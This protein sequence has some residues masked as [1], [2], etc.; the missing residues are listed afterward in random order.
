MLASGRGRRELR[1]PVPT[2]QPVPPKFRGTREQQA[3]AQLEWDLNLAAQRR[4]G[5]LPPAYWDELVPHLNRLGAR[6]L[7]D[8]AKAGQPFPDAHELAA[9]FVSYARQG[10]R[11]SWFKPKGE[12]A[13]FVGIDLELLERAAA[14]SAAYVLENHDPEFLKQAQA[15]GREGGTMHGPRGRTVEL[16]ELD[17]YEGQGI[18]KVPELAKVMRRS[19]RT[20]QRLRADRRKLEAAA[21]ERPTTGRGIEQVEAALWGDQ[22]A[23]SAAPAAD[24][25]PISPGEGQEAPEAVPPAATPLP[26][27]AAGAV[28]EGGD[29]GPDPEQP[30]RIDALIALAFADQD[31]G[32]LLA[33]L[34]EV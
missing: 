12:P 31:H 9:G 3:E 2:D 15:W 25:A 1:F 14:D 26:P 23:R 13:A 17:Y 8:A 22:E 27:A 7:N 18:V 28:E 19:E 34:D 4:A 33:S 21:G 24:T 29:R 30:G 32:Q 20:I 11:G 6:V 10:R 16:S 5:E